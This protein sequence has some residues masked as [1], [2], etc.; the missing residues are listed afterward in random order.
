[1]PSPIDFGATWNQAVHP[2]PLGRR[3]RTRPPL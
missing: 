3:R 2:A 1:M